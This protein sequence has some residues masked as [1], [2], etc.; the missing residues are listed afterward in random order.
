M[1]ALDGRELR[2]L[3][4]KSGIP[5]STVGGY[6]QS[7]I[8]KAEAAVSIAAA[9]GCSVDWLLTGGEEDA[10]AFLPAQDDPNFV[11]VEE[12]DLA[13]GLGWTFAD[14]PVEVTRHRFP[15]DFIASITSSPPHKLT[16]ARGRGDSMQP[17]MQ[18]GDMVIVDRSQ[19]SIREQDAIWALTVGD[20]AM[21][22]RI[23]IRGEKVLI[24]SDNDRVP[25]DEAHHEEVRVVGRVIFIGRRV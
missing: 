3:A 4:E 7:G 25:P 23:R 17:T 15:R 16:I 10:S 5:D 1:L 9:L 12:I 22:K 11:E 19:V 24:L 14:G 13:Y 8:A 20:M 2:W 21:I 18:D 6:I